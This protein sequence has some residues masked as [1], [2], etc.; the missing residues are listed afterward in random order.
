MTQTQMANGV[1][2]G[3]EDN[4]RQQVCQ[5]LNHSLADMEVV[6]TK[7]R[8]YHWNVMGRNFHS[9]HELFEAQYTQLA[10]RIDDVAERVRSIGEHPIGTLQ[11]FMQH[12]HLQEEPGQQPAAMQMVANLLHDHEHIIQELRKGVE[13]CENEFNDVGTADFLTELV[14]EH[15]KMAW[16]L[17]AFIER[18][19]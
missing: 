1:N 10:E 11:E 2:I 16:M 12:S 4:N 3:I 13:D 9:L 14:Q 6:Y 19:D 5:I 15:E 17:R 8:N 18:Q 7:T